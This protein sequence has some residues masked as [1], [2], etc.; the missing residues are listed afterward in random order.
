MTLRKV[1]IQFLVARAQFKL[2]II[3]L[4]EALG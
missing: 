3:A 4:I 1:N 2:A